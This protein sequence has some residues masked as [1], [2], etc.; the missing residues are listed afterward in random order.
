MQKQAANRQ[1]NT[2]VPVCQK[3]EVP[4]FY[5]AARQNVEQERRQLLPIAVGRVSPA[6]RHA[7]FAEA[8]ES[9]VG[10]RH[11]VCVA[12]Q[13]PDDVLS[14]QGEVWRKRPSRD[15]EDPG[16]IDRSQLDLTVFRGDEASFCAAPRPAVRETY[17]ETCG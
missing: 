1:S 9:P 17:R 14:A 13:V 12:R 6:E 5:E 8:D 2:A 15:A 10:D 4:Y 7:A 11:P 16:G 3:R